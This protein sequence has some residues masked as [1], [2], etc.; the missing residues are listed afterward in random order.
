MVAALSVEIPKPSFKS[1]SSSRDYYV[2][3]MYDS[4]ICFSSLFSVVYNLLFPCVV[5]ALRGLLV[6]I[7]QTPELIVESVA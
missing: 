1:Y 4:L 6:G 2:D 3:H 5:K 7:L